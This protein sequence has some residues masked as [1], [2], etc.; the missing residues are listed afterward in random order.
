MK[1][2]YLLFAFLI[3]AG[4]SYYVTKNFMNH[5]QDEEQEPVIDTTTVILPT[6]SDSIVEQKD[7]DSIIKPVVPDPPTPDP[8]PVN[9]SFSE[10]KQLIM[11]GK[12]EKDK[13]ISKK[14]VVEYDDLNDDDADIQ[15][16]LQAVRDMVDYD[17]WKDF[18]VI[19]LGY[20]NQG[21]VN[22]VTIRPVY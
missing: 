13:R 4:G 2:I 12:Y 18:Q 21:R 9:I 10:V 11:N 22:K 6:D 5:Q 19:N 16:N 3:I 20:D 17:N 15:C 8:R 14:Y 7:T 1:K